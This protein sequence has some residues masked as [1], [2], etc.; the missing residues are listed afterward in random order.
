MAE[1]LFGKLSHG[2]RTRITLPI[3]ETNL[4]GQLFWRAMGM[5]AVGVVRG[6]YEDTGEAGYEMEY[7]LAGA[8]EG[9]GV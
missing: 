6:M 3:R 7:R 8:W 9:G 5:K 2:R 1:T 4:A